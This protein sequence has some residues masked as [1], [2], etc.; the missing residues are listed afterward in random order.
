MS[1]PAPAAPAAA[2]A[3][4]STSRRAGDHRALKTAVAVYVGI[5]AMKVART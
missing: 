1:A 5:F 3:P 4:S 2:A